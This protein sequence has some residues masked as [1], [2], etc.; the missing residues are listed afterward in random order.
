MKTM[1]AEG[2]G[3][4][5]YKTCDLKDVVFVQSWEQIYSR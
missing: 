4:L 5:T 3:S 2:V 1:E